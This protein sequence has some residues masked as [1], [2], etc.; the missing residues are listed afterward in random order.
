MFGAVGSTGSISPTISQYAADG[1][2][3]KAL[4]SV[5]PVVGKAIDSAEIEKSANSLQSAILW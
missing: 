2:N 4:L 5:T 1:V 3:R